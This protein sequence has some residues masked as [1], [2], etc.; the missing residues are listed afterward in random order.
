MVS[1]DISAAEGKDWLARLLIIINH[2]Y[3]EED[4]Y[5]AVRFA[6]A[7]ATD[8]HTKVVSEYWPK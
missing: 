7:R 3:D 8:I 1:L 2:I 4:V 5:T 6:P